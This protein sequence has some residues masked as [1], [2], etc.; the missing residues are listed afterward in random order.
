MFRDIQLRTILFYNI[1]RHLLKQLNFLKIVLKALKKKLYS[2]DKDMQQNQLF[3]LLP[4]PLHPAKACAH[5]S[6]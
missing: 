1:T 5:D 2:G 3:P 6:L 4:R